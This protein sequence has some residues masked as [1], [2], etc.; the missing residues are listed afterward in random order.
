MWGPGDS[1]HKRDRDHPMELFPFY[2]GETKAESKR[3]SPCASK[4]YYGASVGSR[5]LNLNHQINSGPTGNASFSSQAEGSSPCIWLKT[6]PLKTQ[7]IMLTQSSRSAGTFWRNN[8]LE[9]K[10]EDRKGENRCVQWLET[11]RPRLGLRSLHPHPSAAACF[12][13]VSYK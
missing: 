3:P 1:E 5:Q 2:R 6:L 8:A 4:F 11:V 12:L 10:G 9:F 13:S 7:L